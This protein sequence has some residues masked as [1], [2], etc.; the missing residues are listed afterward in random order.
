[1]FHTTKKK[2]VIFHRVPRYSMSKFTTVQYIITHAE[3]FIQRQCVASM[4][5]C[6]NFSLGKGYH[7]V[8]NVNC[9]LYILLHKPD[10]TAAVYELKLLKTEI[11]VCEE[12]VA[13]KQCTCSAK[14]PA[15]RPKTSIRH[16][17]VFWRIW[18]LLI[19]YIPWCNTQQLTRKKFEISKFW[20]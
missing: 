4:S 7:M 10:F 3:I 18:D 2:V 14:K 17:C 20:P 13:K 5:T 16:F 12:R 6:Y 19:P 15:P 1:M 11:F 8:G 9:H